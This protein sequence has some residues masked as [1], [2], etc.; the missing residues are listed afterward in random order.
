MI[1]HLFFFDDTATT[2]IYPL[3]Y[4]TLFRSRVRRVRLDVRVAL[5][6]VEDVVGRE[7]DERRTELG[8]VL[9]PSDVDRRRLLRIRLRPVDVRPRRGMQD[10]VDGSEIRRRRQRHVPVTPCQTP[11][12]G[13][14]LVQGGAQ[15]AAGPG[16][17][18]AS[19][20]ESVGDDVLQRC[21]TRSS[22][23]GTPCSSGS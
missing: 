17:E 9:R 18:D 19:R 6:P 16:Y 13:K 21:R 11:R 5:R 23:H 14:R 4:T 2:E 20:V 15:L 3:S 22:S 1:L 8:G 12:L 7:V 10:E